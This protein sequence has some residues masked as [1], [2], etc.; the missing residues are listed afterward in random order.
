MKR[1][2]IKIL[3]AIIFILIISSCRTSRFSEHQ[4]QLVQYSLKKSDLPG[5]GWRVE[6]ES[7]EP[8]YG[9]ESYGIVYI[10]DKLVFINHD[11]AIYS[12]EDQAKQAYKEWENDWFTIAKFQAITSFSPSNVND[13]FRYECEQKE[14]G[15]PLGSLRLCLY[16]QRKKN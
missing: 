1:N 16:L 4:A 6:V 7:W 11:V 10:R 9:G 12:S 3:V 15:T 5:F 14:P 8:A 13:T 2:K